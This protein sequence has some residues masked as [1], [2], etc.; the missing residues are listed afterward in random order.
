MLDPKNLWAYTTV[1]FFVS[2]LQPK[3][4]HGK[5]LGCQ[6]K[7]D[8]IWVLEFFWCSMDFKFWTLACWL[9]CCPW[10][11]YH[12]GQVTHVG[13]KTFLFREHWHFYCYSFRVWVTGSQQVEVWSRQKNLDLRKRLASHDYSGEKDFLWPP[14]WKYHTNIWR[15]PNRFDWILLGCEQNWM[16]VGGMVGIV[17]WYMMYLDVLGQF[18]AR[19]CVHYKLN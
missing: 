18:S 2:A 15:S 6:C 11:S 4:L 1:C 17:S 9:I 5:C 19:T 3:A 14:S 13:G 7:G 10:S 12:A 16:M 8:L